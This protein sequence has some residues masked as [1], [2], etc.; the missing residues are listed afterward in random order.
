MTKPVEYVFVLSDGSRRFEI[1][2]SRRDVAVFVR[3]HHAM[4]AR[5]LEADDCEAI[6]L[7]IRH[8]F[9]AHGTLGAVL[10]AI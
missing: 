5:P 2:T 8:H 7:R 9:G 1:V 4:L 3:L 6:D 10:H